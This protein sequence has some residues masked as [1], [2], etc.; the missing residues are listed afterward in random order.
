MEQIQ[1]PVSQSLPPT[2][3]KPLKKIKSKIPEKSVEKKKYLDD[4]F[5][6]EWKNNYFVV[7]KPLHPPSD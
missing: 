2:N 6:E 1:N 7:G 3:F 5:L 4:L